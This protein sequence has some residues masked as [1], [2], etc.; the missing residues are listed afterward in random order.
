[1]TF[2]GIKI[3]KKRMSYFDFEIFLSSRK[4]AFYAI[5]ISMHNYCLIKSKFE[6]QEAVNLNRLSFLL[7]ILA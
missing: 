7:L 6:K 4:V 5:N 1:M 2:A 3:N